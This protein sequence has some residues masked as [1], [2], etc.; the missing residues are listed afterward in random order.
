MQISVQKI[1]GYIFLHLSWEWKGD[2]LC[3]YRFMFECFTPNSA[4]GLRPNKGSML[5]KFVGIG[6][7]EIGFSMTC[8]LRR[9]AGFYI[10]WSRFW[11]QFIDFIHHG[12]CQ[13]M[14]LSPQN[15][16]HP[17]QS[18]VNPH[19]MKFM[20]ATTPMVLFV[21]ETCDHRFL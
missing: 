7:S 10:F 3:Q 5:N 20:W 9:C 1:M 17:L 14:F 8:P 18:Q 19:F 21:T 6:C 13:A 12:I 4:T 15:L 2:V 11:W 16:C